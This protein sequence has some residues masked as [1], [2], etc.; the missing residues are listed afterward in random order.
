MHLQLIEKW[1]ADK[2]GLRFVSDKITK[3]DEREENTEYGEWKLK[4]KGKEVKNL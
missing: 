1:M 3:K 2:D 4:K